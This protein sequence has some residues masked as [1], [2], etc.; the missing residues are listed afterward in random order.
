MDITKKQF[1]AYEK[2]R[3]SG[4]TN[5]FDVSTVCALSDLTREEVLL[6]MKNYTKLNK[7]YPKVRETNYPRK[8]G[9][10]NLERY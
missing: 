6:I 4:V 5:M 3:Q 9:L 10:V 2:V 8:I 1:I 7:K